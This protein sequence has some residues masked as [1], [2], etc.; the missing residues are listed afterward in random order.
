MSHVGFDWCLCSDNDTHLQGPL[1]V[2]IPPGK[3][4]AERGHRLRH[5][6]AYSLRTGG[7]GQ[8]SRG[9]VST[10][11]VTRRLRPHLQPDKPI[12]TANKTILIFASG[13][14]ACASYWSGS[15]TYHSQDPQ[16]ANVK[17]R[18]QV[19]ITTVWPLHGSSS[20]DAPGTHTCVWPSVSVEADSNILQCYH[21]RLINTTDSCL[22]SLCILWLF[23]LLCFSSVSGAL[24][25]IE[26]E[27]AC[28]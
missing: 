1:L 25:I 21:F 28:Q 5:L 23:N 19:L 7:L 24:P 4:A 6:L 9:K 20:N 27:R 10:S 14:G 3:T 12:V 17:H 2:G 22:T 8:E 15:S 11:K 16:C 18:S 13:N 26:L